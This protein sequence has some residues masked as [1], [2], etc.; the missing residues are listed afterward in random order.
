MNGDNLDMRLLRIISF[1]LLLN[2]THLVGASGLHCERGDPIATDIGGGVTMLTCM[3]EKEPDVVVRTGPLELVKNGILILRAETNSS[4]KL[5]GLYT[6]WSDE[7]EI[8]EKGS[9]F[10]GLK[11]G[12]WIITN[13][14]GGN[15]TIYYEKGVLVKP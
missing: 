3:W 4:G 12:A 13:K 6:S 7:G 15:E 1:L 8:L 11:Q 14:D 5:H 10:E 2:L 9:Y